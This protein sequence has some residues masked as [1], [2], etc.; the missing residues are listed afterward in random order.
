M[1]S[2]CS[3]VQLLRYGDFEIVED[4]PQAGLR[5][6]ERVL[7][8]DVPFLWL[9]PDRLQLAGGCQTERDPLVGPL[10]EQ[11]SVRLTVLLVVDEQSQERPGVAEIAVVVVLTGSD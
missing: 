9:R 6:V 8:G 3:C 1:S 7:E 11:F 5:R 4:G 2:R 10:A